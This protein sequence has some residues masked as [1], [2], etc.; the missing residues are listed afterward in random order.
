MILLGNQLE[1]SL[2]S[3]CWGLQRIIKNAPFYQNPPTPNSAAPSSRRLPRY[4]GWR[5]LPPVWYLGL[6]DLFIN[7]DIQAPA[8]ISD[9]TGLE[10]AQAVAVSRWPHI[11]PGGQLHQAFPKHFCDFDVC[12][13]MP[14]TVSSWK[15]K[16]HVFSSFSFQCFSHGQHLLKHTAKTPSTYWCSLCLW[17]EASDWGDLGQCHAGR[18]SHMSK[19]G[20]RTGSWV[21]HPSSEDQ[22]KRLWLRLRHLG[23]CFHSRICQPLEENNLPFPS[24]STEMIHL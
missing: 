8:W 24:S 4:P 14:W 7:T 11:H 19:G 20:G 6:Q 2:A 10:D 18:G 1:K 3:K 15:H 16:N 9:C 22:A 13:I 21:L 5:C 12:T 17:R 23:A